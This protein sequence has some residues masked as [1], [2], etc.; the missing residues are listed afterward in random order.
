MLALPLTIPAS[1]RWM[2]VFVIRLG[3]YLKM[4]YHCWVLKFSQSVFISL[5]FMRVCMLRIK[6]CGWMFLESCGNRGNWNGTCVYFR[7]VRYFHWLACGH[8]CIMHILCVLHTV[9]PPPPPPASFIYG[10][11]AHATLCVVCVMC[12]SICQVYN[13]LSDS[14]N[15]VVRA[16][17]SHEW[18]RT[19]YASKLWLSFVSMMLYV[20]WTG[21]LC[22]MPG[23]IWDG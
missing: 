15:L 23:I 9:T 10:V 17:D 5:S 16:P 13:C 14:A 19:I 22:P 21:L 18:R 11:F 20:P 3:C 12:T 1:H 8:L 7:L 4:F 2:C 6:Q